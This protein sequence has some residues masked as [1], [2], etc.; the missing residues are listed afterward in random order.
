MFFCVISS[1]DHGFG[2]DRS[3]IACRRA[4]IASAGESPDATSSFIVGTHF[5]IPV[6]VIVLSPI[7][8]RVFSGTVGTSGTIGAIG[9]SSLLIFFFFVPAS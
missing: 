7:S 6:G 4:S 5:G 1:R 9:V 3:L 8:A 2:A